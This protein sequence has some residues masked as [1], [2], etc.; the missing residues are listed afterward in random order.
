MFAT[1]GNR[2]GTIFVSQR[3]PVRV[4]T[5]LHVSAQIETFF[6]EL[7]NEHLTA[8]FRASYA[9]AVG[10]FKGAMRRSRFL[11]SPE[12]RSTVEW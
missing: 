11:F 9:N 6:S 7:S 2:F 5:K 4:G 10:V 12:T 3:T 8:H 1:A